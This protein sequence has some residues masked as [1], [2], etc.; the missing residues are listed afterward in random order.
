MC[1]ELKKRMNPAIGTGNRLSTSDDYA[2]DSA[3]NTTADP[4][5]RQFIYDGENKQVKVL[6]D[7]AAAIGEYFYDGDGKRVKKYVPATG[8]VTVF[9]YDAAG[10]QIAE[11]STIVA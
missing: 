10:K 1:S 8:E 7:Q 9:V 6:D 5:D 4:D 11:Y 2:F 3:G